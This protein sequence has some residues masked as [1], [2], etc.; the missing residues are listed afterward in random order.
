MDDEPRILNLG[1]GAPLKEG[2][3]T[4]EFG[5]DYAAIAIREEERAEEK[6]N[7]RRREW[8]GTFDTELPC[9]CGKTVMDHAT[10]RDPDHRLSMSKVRIGPQPSTREQLKMFRPHHRYWCDACGL[11]YRA[12]V[13]EGARGYVPRDKRAEFAG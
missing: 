2:I 3:D 12:S 13:I 5:M 6:L 4:R 8:I 9:A 1:G 7:Y 10:I 11:T